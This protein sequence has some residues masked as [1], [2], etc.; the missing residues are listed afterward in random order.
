MFDALEMI[1][2]RFAKL[3]EK[4]GFIVDSGEASVPEDFDSDVPLPFRPRA[5]KACRRKGRLL[6][7]PLSHQQDP[8][9]VS[10]Q[11]CFNGAT[12]EVAIYR[13]A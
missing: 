12:K 13:G 7:N 4:K 5:P 3:F 1:Y 11:G 2:L 8:K 9:I 6:A 10:L